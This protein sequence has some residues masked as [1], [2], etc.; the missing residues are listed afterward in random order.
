MLFT[1][2]TLQHVLLES[3]INLCGINSK[4]SEN[5]KLKVCRKSVSLYSTEKVSGSRESGHLFWTHKL[6]ADGQIGMLI[7]PFEPITE[8]R[9]QT[10]NL[11]I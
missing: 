6:T 7:A 4:T 8:H 9:I 10:V 2:F 1:E 11:E 5:N 3:Q